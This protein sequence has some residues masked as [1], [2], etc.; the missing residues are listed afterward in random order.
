MKKQVAVY[1]ETG[2]VFTQKK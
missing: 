2:I 1:T